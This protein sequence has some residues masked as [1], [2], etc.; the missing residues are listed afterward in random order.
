MP[1]GTPVIQ[2]PVQ[3]TPTRPP[4]QP[5]GAVAPD[6][7][8]KVTPLPTPQSVDQKDGNGQ[9][10]SDMEIPTFIRRQMD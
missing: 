8:R 1:R 6:I 3:R 5:R 7:P 4:M 10:L 9:D 2:L